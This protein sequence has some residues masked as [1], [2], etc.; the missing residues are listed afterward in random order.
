MDSFSINEQIRHVPSLYD[1]PKIRNEINNQSF[2]EQAN[3]LLII[4]DTLCNARSKQTL[5]QL[6]DLICIDNFSLVEIDPIIIELYQNQG[7]MRA[8]I[9]I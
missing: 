8:N 1:H 9:F 6:I 4:F 3:L 5:H 2:H 7:L